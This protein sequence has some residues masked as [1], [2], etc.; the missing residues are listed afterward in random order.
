MPAWVRQTLYAVMLLCCAIVGM[1]FYLE[2]N[3]SGA[4]APA[5]GSVS[6]SKLPDT[7]P[8]FSLNDSFGEQRSISEW[9]GKPLLINFWATWCAPC[10]REMPLLQALH[11]SQDDLQVLGIAIDRPADVQTYLAESGITYPSL[12]GEADAMAASDQFGLE[13]LGLPFTILVS[14]SGKIVTV[15]IGEIERDEL[16][17]LAATARDLEA[18][19]INLV[20]ARQRLENL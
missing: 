9:A 16:N 5:A 3:R 10:R 18:G 13:G 17:Q 7:L 14:S 20:Y 15:F 12:V 19:D 1:R 6:S 8:D 4:D 11:T 2:L